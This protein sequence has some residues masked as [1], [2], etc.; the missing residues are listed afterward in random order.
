[1]SFEGWVGDG[2]SAA[3]D[4][5][6]AGRTYVETTD[7]LVR[8]KYYSIPLFAQVLE[9]QDW[10]FSLG[11]ELGL[12]EEVRSAVY[13][14][15]SAGYARV[16]VH[17]L[18]LDAAIEAGATTA[19]AGLASFGA[20]GAA[21]A[22]AVVLAAVFGGG[23]EDEEKKKAEGRRR[24]AAELERWSLE[25]FAAEQRK[26]ADR[27]RIRARYAIPIPALPHTDWKAIAARADQL[28]VFYD[29][30]AKI[31]FPQGRVLF[32]ATSNL[33]RWETLRAGVRAMSRD[34]QRA[35]NA[36]AGGDLRALLSARIEAE[37]RRLQ[38]VRDQMRWRA[39]VAQA[40]R[41]GRSSLAL[42]GALAALALA[43]RFR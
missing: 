30:A 7:T 34:A 35:L 12:G 43:W 42:P 22:V 15:R 6:A 4:T 9:I 41:R 19:M 16:A 20:L 37:G 39:R 33:G 31:P 13:A 17:T 1:M 3:E 21:G 26:K 32:E 14:I 36:L 28:A 24:V 40:Q 8:N 5:L 38:T 18:G 23:D 2:K 29:R 11:D 10:I 27:A 25:R